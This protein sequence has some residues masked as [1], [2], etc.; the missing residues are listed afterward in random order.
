MF[1]RRP[2]EDDRVPFNAGNVL[3]YG[4]AAEEKRKGSKKLSKI[5]GMTV[6][7]ERSDSREGGAELDSVLR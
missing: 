2:K 3:Q 1:A 7:A 4:R 6:E 5:V